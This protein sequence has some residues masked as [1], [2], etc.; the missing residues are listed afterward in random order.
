MVHNTIPNSFHKTGTSEYPCPRCHKGFLIPVDTS[1]HYE[2]TADSLD[3]RDIEGWE[4]DWTRYVYSCIFRCNHST[5]KEY[6]A[7]SGEGTVSWEPVMTPD[8]KDMEY[9][10]YFFPKHFH[11]NLQFFPVTSSTPEEVT[12]ALNKSFNTFFLTLIQH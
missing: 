2:E 6:V 4:P 1:F 8:G 7:S 3:A 12:N 11:P 9:V 10:E 5:C